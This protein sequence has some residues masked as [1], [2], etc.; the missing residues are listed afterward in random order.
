VV[1]TGYGGCTDFLDERTGWVVEHSL[2]PLRRAHGPY[3]A[4]A[5]WAEP[6]VRH[7]AEMMARV[8]ADPEARA[9]KVEAAQRRVQ[10]LYAPAAA[11]ERIRRE[12][13]RILADRRGQRPLPFPPAAT[14]EA[15][16]AALAAGDEAAERPL[17]VAAR[18]QPVRS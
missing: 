8:V 6:D 15:P 16:G 5:V 3:P 17:A 10:E 11:G 7:A 4:G 9:R 18:A 2:V 13:E 1:A 14:A 12:I